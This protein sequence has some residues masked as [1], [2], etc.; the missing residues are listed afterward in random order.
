VRP[1]AHA[2]L[3][4]GGGPAGLATAIELSRRGIAAL[5]VERSDY[6]DVRVGEH[7]YPAAVLQLRDIQS[8]A[9]LPLDAH[10]TSAGIEAYWGSATPNYLDYFVHPGQRGLNLLRPQF[11]ADL[12]RACERSGATVARSAILR[13]ARQE[14]AGWEAD[15]AIDGKTRCF[16]VSVIV[17]ATGRA[18]AFARSQG[19]Q[20]RADDRQIAVVSLKDD[21]HHA[22]D[23]RSLVETAEIGWW[24]G[25]SIGASRCICMLVTDDDLLPPHARTDLSAWWR[26][27]QQRTTHVARRFAG[28]GTADRLVVRSARSQRT[29]PA[30]GAGWVAVGDAAMAFDPMASQGI[31]KALEHAERA[32]AGIAA[33]LA[34]DTACLHGF[35]DELAQEYSAYRAKRAAYYRGETRWPDA[36]FWQRRHHEA[37]AS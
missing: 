27:Q 32:A 5:V 11:D 17:D 33:Y 15:V 37:V 19:A 4:V 36:V 7:L 8:A 1:R 34:G 18:A 20:V 9:H 14:G 12:A 16:Q 29:E 22:T 13:R 26:D 23:T 21:A 25:A 3:I 10:G 28:G 31:A 35:A 30:C 6:D 24:Y 2:V